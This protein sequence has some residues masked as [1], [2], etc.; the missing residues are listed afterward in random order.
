LQDAS[1]VQN[2]LSTPEIRRI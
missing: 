1:Y 2:F